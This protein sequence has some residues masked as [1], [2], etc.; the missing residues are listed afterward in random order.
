MDTDEKESLY[1]IAKDWISCIGYLFAVKEVDKAYTAF[2]MGDLVLPRS[3]IMLKDF[4]FT[5][6]TLYSSKRHQLKL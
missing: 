4:K 6:N 5:L 3:L 2:H 1:A